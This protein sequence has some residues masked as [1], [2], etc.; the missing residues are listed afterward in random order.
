MLPN[1][2]AKTTKEER[3]Q[4]RVKAQAA[5]EAG[6]A[7]RLQRIAIKWGKTVDSV[8]RYV[9]KIPLQHQKRQIQAMC[10]ELSPMKSIAQCCRECCGFEDI[11]LR[12]QT[13][14][15]LDCPLHAHRPYQD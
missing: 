3:L 6:L 10:G 14:A 15:A 5:W 7:S 4:A 12:I 2:L 8:K 13:C 1:F 11:P 9:D